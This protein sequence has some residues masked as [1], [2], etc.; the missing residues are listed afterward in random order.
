[1]KTTRHFFAASLL[2]VTLALS[3]YAGDIATPVATQP[4]P[5]SSPA[6]DDSAGTNGD[7]HFPRASEAG[8]QDPVLEAALSLLQSVLSLF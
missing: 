6:S 4:P 1:M 2:V 3:A 8:G 5:P 7:I